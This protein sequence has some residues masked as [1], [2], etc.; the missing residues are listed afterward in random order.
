MGYV[1]STYFEHVYDEYSHEESDFV[2]SKVDASKEK[3]IKSMV[4][5]DRHSS[6]VAGS[7]SGSGRVLRMVLRR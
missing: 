1:R 4:G 2:F 3:I 6:T 7:A 5:S